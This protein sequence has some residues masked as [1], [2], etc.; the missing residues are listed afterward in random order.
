MV[1][2]A[3]LSYAVCDDH[4]NELSPCTA[5]VPLYSFPGVPDTCWRDAAA[6]KRAVKIT[7]YSYYVACFGALE[8]LHLLTIWPPSL[9]ALLSPLGVLAALIVV[10]KAVWARQEWIDTFF[11]SFAKQQRDYFL[12]EFFVYVVVA[13]I[14][15]IVA[16]EIFQI[17]LYDSLYDALFIL[18]LGYFAAIDNTLTVSRNWYLNGV[19]QRVDS[20]RLIPVSVTLRQAILSLL[21]A[22]TLFLLAA[23]FRFHDGLTYAKA[24]APT[25][26]L[27]FTKELLFFLLVLGTLLLRISRSYTNN[28]HYI[29]ESQLKVIRDA[30]AGDYSQS[31]PLLTQSELGLM[32]LQLNRLIEYMRKR[33]D[34]ENLL[35]Q[36]V[37]PDIMEKLINTDTEK[38]KRGEEREVAILFCDIRGFTEMSEG[39]SAADVIQFLNAFFAELTEIVSRNHGTINKFMGDAILA[40]YGTDS[41]DNS[42]SAAR[43]A[44][45]AAINTAYEITLRVRQIRLPN[46][47]S[48]E[49]G[50]GI[51]FGRVVAGTIG[52]A[53]RYE[54]TFLGDAVNTASRLQGLS[55]RFGYPIIV[56]AE[57]YAMVSDHLRTGLTDL[58]QHKVR[59]KADA[60]H[61]F[62]GPNETRE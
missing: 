19:Q 8:L 50:T 26:V 17:S 30:Q 48:P 25:L 1:F 45:D 49:T 46:G 10:D 55:R 58:G 14:W 61:I 34:I 18:L 16:R 4:N 13:L 32:G 60:L 11:S 57:A 44:V 43:Q 23:V 54:Y 9:V 33:Q 53:Q 36:V 24:P 22:I 20:F 12:H 5:F 28:I 6:M 40:V 41:A 59:G 62:G 31:I 15:V 3:C 56:S 51:H 52:S 42:I 2:A 37:S 21:S 39:A 7:R 27:N 47:G 38:L 29:M 35:K